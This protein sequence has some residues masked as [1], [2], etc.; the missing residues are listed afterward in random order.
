MEK[1]GFSDSAAGGKVKRKGKV[2]LNAVEKLKWPFLQ[3]K[4]ELLRGNLERLKSTLVLMLNVLTY[5]RGLREEY[6]AV[7]GRTPLRMLADDRK[8]TSNAGK[9][10]RTWRTVITRSC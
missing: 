2:V 9:K 8:L 1:M 6:V 3:P 4:M 5:A 7:T 10:S